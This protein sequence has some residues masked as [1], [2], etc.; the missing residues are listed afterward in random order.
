MSDVY[1][2]DT[3]CMPAMLGDMSLPAKP[4]PEE[5]LSIVSSVF[6]SGGVVTTA[7]HP[8]SIREN[9]MIVGAP[10]LGT[11]GEVLYAL[12]LCAPVGSVEHGLRDA[13]YILSACLGIAMILAIAVS[14]ILSHRFVTPLGRMKDA[15]TRLISG[16]TAAKTGVA[17]DDEIGVLAA[18][19]DELA[20]R[21]EAAQKERSQLDQMRQDFFSDISHELR[22]PIA[23]VKG[24]VEL[25]REG[26]ISGADAVHA[27]YSQL[28][29]DVTHIERLVNDLLELTRLQNVHFRIEMG[30]LNLGDVLRD[31]VRSM[32]QRAAER[33]IAIHMEDCASPFPVMGDY[34]RLRQLMIILLDN[35]IKFSPED[36]AIRITAERTAAG[37]K[38]CIADSGPGID[39][40]TLAHIF[41]RY[42]HN[43]SSRNRG[44]TGLG[45]P[46]AREIALRHQVDFSCE[47]TPGEGTRFT[48][49]FPECEIPEE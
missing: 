17:Q 19:I 3:Q 6:G 11:Q 16:D 5:A 2:L 44:G 28:Y 15:T 37:C 49:V 27:C 10:V 34:G 47:S 23:V 26:L 20:E 43:R 14:D 48:L 35:A 12:L 29:A 21:L 30:L 32:R 13:F 39:E 22:T 9:R 18:H 24:R 25:L 36:A 40:E 46:I 33:R 4:L 45:L 38:V 31:T 8:I 42:F 1:L 41:D 7:Y